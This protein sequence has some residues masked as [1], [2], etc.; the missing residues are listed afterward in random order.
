MLLSLDPEHAVDAGTATERAEDDVEASDGGELEEFVRDCGGLLETLCGVPAVNAV[1]VR[2]LSARLDGLA[3]VL[4]SA[5]VATA[6]LRRQVAFDAG[7]ALLF[8]SDAVHHDGDDATGVTAHVF[9][10]AGRFATLCRLR[11][12][13]PHKGCSHTCARPL[14]VAGA[15]DAGVNDR[16]HSQGHEYS[17]LLQLSFRV[18]RGCTLDLV[19]EVVRV[20]GRVWGEVGWVVNCARPVA[21]LALHGA[22]SVDAVTPAPEAVQLA[23]VR[24]VSCFALTTARL[25][26]ELRA[27][28][29]FGELVGTF[30]RATGSLCAAAQ[31]LLFE[32]TVAVLLL[33]R[34]GQRADAESLERFRAFAAAYVEWPK[35]SPHSSTAAAVPS[36]VRARSPRSAASLHWSRGWF[37]SPFA[38]PG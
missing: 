8:F 28:A 3:G 29:A 36:A 12:R 5:A 23:C 1:V 20:C 24:T 14:P 37:T 18:L 19:A 38:P 32:S 13:A 6:E 22:V 26:D 9:Q 30:P 27:S 34:E 15:R 21:Q 4:D 33:P 2:E 11:V 16:L 31:A 35:P 10:C 7:S 17:R 25:R